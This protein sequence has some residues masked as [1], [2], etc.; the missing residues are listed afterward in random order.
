MDRLRAMEIFVSVSECGSFRQAASSLGVS[1]ASVTEWIKALESRLGVTLIQRNS[2]R[3]R[4]T[5]EGVHYYNSCVEVLREVHRA[6][7]EIRSGAET[8]AGAIRIE[9][10]VTVGQTL[11]FPLVESFLKK[12]PNLTFTFSLTNTPRNMIEHGT[13]VAIRLDQ[14]DSAENWARPIFDATSIVCAA[15]EFAETRR[16]P[17]NPADLDP[18]LC[19]GVLSNG[20]YAPRRWRFTRGREVAQLTPAGP[21]NCSSTPVLIRAA[22]HGVGLINVFDVLAREQLESGRLVQLYPDWQGETRTYYAVAPSARFVSPK[23]RAFM[24]HI[25]DA[26]QSAKTTVDVRADGVQ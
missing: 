25:S 21:F 22:M 11:I 10:T 3:L 4:L 18:A 16:L 1:N 20:R 6:E 13:D 9:A 12:H 5:E 8:F 19:L 17:E 24:Q 23:V 7:D 2:R 26:Y 15:P 14:V